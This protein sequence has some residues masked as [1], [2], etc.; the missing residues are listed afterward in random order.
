MRFTCCPNLM[1]L[2]SLDWKCSD[3][4]IDH[5][6][7]VSSAKLIFIFLTLGKSKLILLIIFLYFGQVTVIL[8]SLGNTLG[9]E[10]QSKPTPFDKKSRTTHRIWYK[11]F[12]RIQSAGV[13]NWV[14]QSINRFQSF[15]LLFL[16]V[17]RFSDFCNKIYYAC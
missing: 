3:F 2:A 15:T 12:S 10:K 17:T 14:P 13:K 8:L 7:T 5:F 9:H 4:Q 1:I 16:F 6:A 11:S